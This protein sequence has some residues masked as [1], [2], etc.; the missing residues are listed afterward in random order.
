MCVCRSHRVFAHRTNHVPVAEQVR[1]FLPPHPIEPGI[2]GRHNSPP[3]PPQTHVSAC[4][5]SMKSAQ[6]FVE[7]TT[8]AL[9]P[10]A[11]RALWKRVVRPVADC[12][13]SPLHLLCA[14]LRQI[15]VLH[16]CVAPA[17]VAFPPNCHLFFRRRLTTLPSFLHPP[18][19]P[20]PRVTL[21]TS[22]HRLFLDSERRK[23]P[24]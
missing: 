5:R 17:T 23:P 15:T 22:F 18:P 24:C 9:F 12:V 8:A 11:A 4:A 3:T 19:T 7:S 1:Y 13:D 16:L 6:S 20:T 21:T 10:K 2:K 14:R